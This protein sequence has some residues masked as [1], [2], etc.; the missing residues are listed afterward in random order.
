MRRAL[1]DAQL[2]CWS[3]KAAHD[4]P[5]GLV[6]DQEHLANV[7]DAGGRTVLFPFDVK[8]M[9]TELSKEAVMD[10]VTWIINC[11]PGWE[12]ARAPAG[13]GAHYPRG[14]C[15]SMAAGRYT[16]RV[17]SGLKKQAGEVYMSLQAVLQ[18]VAFDIQESVMRCGKHL[19]WQTAGIPMGSYISAIIAGI[20]VAVAEHRFYLRLPAMIAE[21]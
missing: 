18:L 13:R 14:A 5:D 4:F 9:F 17:G 1:E 6:A 7:G 20:T 10:A 3:I 12:L 11:N 19:L 8:A 16:A 2:R 21:I 15:I